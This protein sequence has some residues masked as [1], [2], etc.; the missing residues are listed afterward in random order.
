MIPTT[1]LERERGQ[2]LITSAAAIAVFLGFLMFAVHICVNLYAN[3]TVTASAYDA[4]RRVAR[5]EVADGDRRAAATR[6]EADLKENLGRYSSRI[7]DIDWRITDDV[8]E[9]HIV[10]ENPSF[11]IFTDADVGVGEIDK[12]VRVRVERVR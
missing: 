1:A 4:A 9:L 2:S 3:T 10:V 12:T 8:V 7:R 11:L 5:A 6:A